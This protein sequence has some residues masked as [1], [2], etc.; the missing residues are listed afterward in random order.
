[1][2]ENLFVNP[3][4]LI[5]FSSS[6]FCHTEC[7]HRTGRIFSLESREIE[8][9]IRNQLLTN[10][11]LELLGNIGS[12]WFQWKAWYAQFVLPRPRV[13]IPR[14]G[15]RARLGRGYWVVMPFIQGNSE[16]I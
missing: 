13:N 14:Y 1:M 2:Q 11:E 9:H 3:S 5:G 15:S 12:Q 6:G 8:C 4:A 16:R 10:P 7:F